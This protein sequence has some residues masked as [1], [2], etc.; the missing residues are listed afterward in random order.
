[1]TRHKLSND[2]MPTL[3]RERSAE[4]FFERFPEE[5]ERSRES[6]SKLFELVRELEGDKLRE[7]RELPIPEV[8]EAAED[9]CRALRWS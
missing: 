7:E 3:E 2:C 5:Y 9:Y 4:E 1:M 8:A 6:I